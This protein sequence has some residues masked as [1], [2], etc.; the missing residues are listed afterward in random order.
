ML[1]YQAEILAFV[2]NRNEL[3]RR[4]EL[5]S[6]GKEP[7]AHVDFKRE[8]STRFPPSPVCCRK[9]GEKQG[10]VRPAPT[11]QPRD[12]CGPSICSWW[13]QNSQ[14]EASST[15]KSFCSQMELRASWTCP[16]QTLPYPGPEHKRG[17]NFNAMMLQQII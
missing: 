16:G 11:Q 12:P 10:P 3:K 14:R 13:G 17:T 4:F 2:S 1:G 5:V 9:V 8:M 15:Q 7:N 6:Q